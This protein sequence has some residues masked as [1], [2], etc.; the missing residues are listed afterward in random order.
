M[1]HNR[2]QCG[3]SI[4]FFGLLGFRWHWVAELGARHPFRG[5]KRSTV[6]HSLKPQLCQGIRHLS[7]TSNIDL[8]QHAE[9]NA[10][11]TILRSPA[12]FRL[13]QVQSL[14]NFNS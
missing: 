11:A 7:G 4:G 10:G 2:C 12:E 1:V 14:L 5:E 6:W 3:A 8:A 13:R 9:W